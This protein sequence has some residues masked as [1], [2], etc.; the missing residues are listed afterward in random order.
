MKRRL[1][2]KNWSIKTRVT[3]WYTVLMA[4]LLFVGLSYI[5]WLSDRML[6]QNYRTS[7]HLVV[8]EEGARRDGL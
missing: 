3:I 6:L 8:E 7:L 4:V 5:F 2:I 1:S